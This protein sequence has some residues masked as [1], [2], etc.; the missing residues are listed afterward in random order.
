MLNQFLTSVI[1]TERTKAKYL[2]SKLGSA[3]GFVSTS[4][5]MGK[6]LNWFD[7]TKLKIMLINLI[8]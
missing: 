6:Y 8:L 7:K 3:F 1:F 5:R 2:Y 4:W